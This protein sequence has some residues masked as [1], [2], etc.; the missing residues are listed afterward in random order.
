MPVYVREAEEIL[1]QVPYEDFFGDLGSGEW[2]KRQ[3]I[4]LG[5]QVHDFCELLEIS[6]QALWYWETERWPLPKPVAIAVL[7]MS[8]LKQR[9]DL[10]LRQFVSPPHLRNCLLQE[11]TAQ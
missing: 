6:R 5:Y 9:G 10:S 8:I 11:A 3:R 2:L 4:Y 7:C 1:A